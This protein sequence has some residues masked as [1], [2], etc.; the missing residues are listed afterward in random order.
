[1]EFIW[2][3][4]SKYYDEEKT[5]ILL[6]ILTSITLSI[7]QTNVISSFNAKIINSLHERNFI[8]GISHFKW[9]MVLWIIYILIT[10]VYKLHQNHILTK[11]RQWI[12]FKITES[13]MISNNLALSNMNF[14]KL[15]APISRVSTTCFSLASDIMSYIIP[16]LGFII[17][18]LFFLFSYS[19]NLGLIFTVGNILWILL[20]KGYLNKLREL[21]QIYESSSVKTETYLAEILNNMDK[22]IVRGQ[23]NFE[24]KSFKLLMTDTINNAQNYYS[25]VSNIMLGTDLIIIV[26]IFA[27]I[28]YSMNMLKEKTISATSFITLFTLLILFREKVTTIAIQTADFVELYGRTEAVV[29]WFKDFDMFVQDEDIIYDDVDLPFNKIKFTNVSFK[30]PNTEDFIFEDKSLEMNTIDH[31]IIGITG[32]SGKGKSTIMKII[33]KL[34]PITSGEITIDDHSIATLDPI[35][36]RDNMTYINQNSRLFDKTI[37]DNIMYGCSD[38][39]VCKNHYEKIMSF[40]RIVELFKEQ[41][42]TNDTVG[43]SGEKISGG[44]R[45]MVN[46][47]SGLVNPSKILILDEPTNALDKKLKLE[48]LEIIK[49]F[50]NFKQA[51]VIITH[52]SDVTPLFDEH[53]KV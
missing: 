50:K 41:D 15:S 29:H 11:L 19:I 25:T 35:Y 37:I 40:P 12:R 8:D 45:Q 27:C 32:L 14:T 4:L 7:L 10:R 2:N 42:L 21:S 52:D 38:E 33:L 16:N 36:L 23:Y 47:I 1:M 26:T 30:Y 49:Y 13:L 5:N 9:F 48:L 34:Y 22:V 3:L 17:I 20:L 46:I 51:I 53:I 18:S 31:N 39:D 44:Q 24:N 6:L 28:A 43:F